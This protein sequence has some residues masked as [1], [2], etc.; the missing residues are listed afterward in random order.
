MIV[1]MMPVKKRVSDD[2]FHIQTRIGLI[3]GIVLALII[4]TLV[5]LGLETVEHRFAEPTVEQTFVP[6]STT[7]LLQPVGEP[8]EEEPIAEEPTSS[9]GEYNN[10]QTETMP[11]DHKQETPT[12]KPAMAP[13]GYNEETG[14]FFLQLHAYQNYDY[15]LL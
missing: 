4:A 10:V 2:F 5:Y 14:D 1:Q 8:P 11:K 3:V 7:E 12:P 6:T 9:D 13:K 15:A